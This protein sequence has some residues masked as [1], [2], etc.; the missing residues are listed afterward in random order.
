MFLFTCLQLYCYECFLT[1]P[2]LAVGSQTG[3]A[4]NPPFLV[5]TV[6]MGSHIVW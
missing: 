4:V 2:L 6:F 5:G 3:V 1:A